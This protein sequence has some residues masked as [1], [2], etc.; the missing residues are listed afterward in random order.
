M[1]GLGGGEFHPGEGYI[2]LA[3]R[4][5]AYPVVPG[6]VVM[7]EFGINIRR[8][9]FIDEIPVYVQKI[10]KGRGI[11][12]IVL[13]LDIDLVTGAVK[14]HLYVIYRGWIEPFDLGGT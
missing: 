11:L 5:H 3:K 14:I 2:I 10:D 6:A 12:Y 8:G 4:S 1:H 7:V 13:G 9:P